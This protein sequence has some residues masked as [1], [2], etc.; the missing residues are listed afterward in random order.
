MRQA[1]KFLWDCAL[2]SVS[3]QMFATVRSARC[4]TGDWQ[5]GLLAQS[6]G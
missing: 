3:S 6:K 2:P 1:H 5:T 4:S